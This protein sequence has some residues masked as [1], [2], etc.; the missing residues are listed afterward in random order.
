MT[1][2]GRPLYVHGDH[3]RLAQCLCNLLN[4]SAKY[5]DP[6]GE[7][8]LTVSD[9][10]DSIT[11]E[12]RDNGAGISPELLP[13]IFD[14]F[15]QAERSLDRSQGG[16]GIGL[17]VVKRLVEM[18]HG[19]VHAASAGVGRG[20]TFS[21]RLPRIEPPEEAAPDN[22]HQSGP[23]RRIL[24]VDD[25]SDAADSLAM[26]LRLE[27]HEVE[28]AYTATRAL[29]AVECKKSEAVLLDIGL[30]QMSG[31]EIARRLRA[32]PSTVEIHL[33]ALSGYG[34]KHDR[35]RS[36]GA[37]FDAHLVKPAGIEP[38]KQILTSLP[39]HA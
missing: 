34:Q 12:V 21:I 35:E 28:T 13:R 32:D 9:A 3:A 11:F 39:P 29:E 16:L 33:I 19:T 24:V 6:G 27:G 31:Y 1:R 22:F 2:P 20:A 18:H 25:N 37:Q 30:P 5:T 7:I 14:L 8:M 15:V 4:N 17:F 23:R 10:P 26:L 38:I 36:A